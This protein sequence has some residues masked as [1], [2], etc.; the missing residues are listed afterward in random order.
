MS[1]N[2]DIPRTAEL[3][4]NHVAYYVKERVPL[5]TEITVAEV[6]EYIDTNDSELAPHDHTVAHALFDLADEGWLHP[7]VWSGFN[8]IPTRSI[9][10]VILGETKDLLDYGGVRISPSCLSHNIAL[11]FKTTLPPNNVHTLTSHEKGASQPK[12]SAS[13][14]TWVDGGLYQETARVDDMA[15]PI[16][17]LTV[18]HTD[19]TYTLSLNHKTIWRN[20]NKLEIQ[21]DKPNKLKRTLKDLYALATLRQ[22]DEDE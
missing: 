12:E 10:D 8:R 13:E 15:T 3:V 20:L 5:N 11:I 16:A 18:N 17:D 9:F 6:Q 1:N 2:T 7:T 21:G 19:K 14:I 22:K 4:A